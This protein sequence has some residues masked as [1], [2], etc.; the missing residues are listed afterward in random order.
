[1]KKQ[2]TV[3]MSTGSCA[4]LYELLSYAKL[5]GMDGAAKLRVVATLHSLRPAAHKLAAARKDCM[6]SL[7]PA[8]FE[9]RL[10][11]ARDF[12]QGK[13]PVKMQRSEYEQF[14]SELQDYNR[15]VSEGVKPISEE[16]VG[17][18]PIT[19]D[20]YEKL[21]DANDWTLGQLSSISDIVKPKP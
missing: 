5:T 13:T 3:T 21:F 15:L 10:Q 14:I 9:R 17:V 18:T 7:R 16:P 1:M 8:D 2:T 6:Q 12:E 19:P 20:D 11:D 4:D